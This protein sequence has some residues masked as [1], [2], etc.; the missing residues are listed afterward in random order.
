MFGGKSVSADTTRGRY[1]QM[2]RPS[3]ACVVQNSASVLLASPP[4]A[5][6]T[7]QLSGYICSLLKHAHGAAHS[8]LLMSCGDDR[9]KSLFGGKKF[10]RF[11][12]P[13]ELNLAIVSMV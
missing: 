8:L 3:C 4:V 12:I 13:S 1:S 10:Q 6:L 9:V 7:P 11:L 2:N 5:H